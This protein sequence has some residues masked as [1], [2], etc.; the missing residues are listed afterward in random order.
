M[1]LILGL[2]IGM[3]L[4]E[5]QAVDV[6]AMPFSVMLTV[7]LAL[8][9]MR[10]ASRLGDLETHGL[11]LTLFAILAPLA[12]GSLT[13]ALASTLGL[14][15]AAVILLGTLAASASYNCSTGSSCKGDSRGQP[16]CVPGPAARRHFSVQCVGR[17]LCL[18]PDRCGDGQRFNWPGLGRG[19]R[20]VSVE[21]PTIR[22]ETIN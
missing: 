21:V 11:G 10:V 8:M 16:C 17:N 13:V 2:V 9:G 4:G 19:F 12:L 18:S 22:E 6:V 20:R 1:L 5:S 15:I 3:V 7:F 14:E